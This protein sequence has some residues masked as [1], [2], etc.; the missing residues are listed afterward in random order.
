MSVEGGSMPEIAE[1]E[2]VRNTLKERILHKKIVDFKAFYKPILLDDE[3]YFKENLI[4][5]EFIDIKRIGK[6]LL[7]ETDTH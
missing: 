3:N 6:W 5:K 2:T 4:G 7:F 1:V